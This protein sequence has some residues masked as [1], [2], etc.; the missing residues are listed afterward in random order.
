M[1]APLWKMRRRVSI[2]SLVVTFTLLV[3]TALST[4]PSGRD[5]LPLTII[6]SPTQTPTASPLPPTDTPTTT[7]TPLPPS[8]EP[9]SPTPAPTFTTHTVQRGETL[10]RISQQYAITFESLVAANQP[11]DPN[12]IYVG[13]MLVIPSADGYVPPAIQTPLPVGYSAYGDTIHLFTTNTRRR[14]TVNG[15]TSDTFILMSPEVEENIRRIYA[16]G[17]AMGRNPRAFSKLGDSTIEN[18]HFLARFDEGTYHLGAYTYLQPVIDYYAGSFGRSSAA[19]RRGL[20]TWSV[21]DPMWAVNP[22]CRGGEHMLECEF[23]VHNPSF[24][25]IRLG[26]NDAGIPESVDKNLRRIVE[27][28]IENGVI[29]IMATKADR[30]EGASNINNEIIRRIAVAYKLPLWDFDLLAGTIPGRGLGGDGVH[31]TSYYA[32]DWR[33]PAALQTGHGVHSLTALMVLEKLMI[34]L[35][36]VTLTRLP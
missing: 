5:V 25:F 13:Q 32:H 20:H 6:P 30:F 16:A 23:R 15:L 17:Q 29:P 14:D 27:Y 21:L 33:N 28:C 8:P 11:I 22:A 24:L 10:F 36:S 35:H 18:P 26:S 34:T 9:V 7:A 2:L 12:R 31:M 1:E 4:Q 19:V 3:I